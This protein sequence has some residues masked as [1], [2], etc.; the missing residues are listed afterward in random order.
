M[1]SPEGLVSPSFIAII[2]LLNHVFLWRWPQ[3]REKKTCGTWN[4]NIRL[5]GTS[6]IDRA[7]KKH[8]NMIL[9]LF[10]G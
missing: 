3:K 5:L 1:M 2:A 8:L 9:Y 10:A 4:L 7:N 6:Y